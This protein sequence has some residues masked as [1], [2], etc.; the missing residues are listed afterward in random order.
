MGDITKQFCFQKCLK[1]KTVHKFA[2]KESNRENMI[3]LF[4]QIKITDSSYDD[5]LFV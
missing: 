5:N 2:Q 1:V 4:E 3:F